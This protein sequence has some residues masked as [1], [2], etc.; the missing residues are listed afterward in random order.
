MSGV[1]GGFW[2]PEAASSILNEDSRRNE[3]SNAVPFNFS[4]APLAQQRLMLPI[5]KHRRQILHSLENFGVVIIVGET[6][7]GMCSA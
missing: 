4:R 1:S 3:E 5:Y 2:K 6:G 7:C